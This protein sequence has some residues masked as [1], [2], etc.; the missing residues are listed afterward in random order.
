MFKDLKSKYQFC[1]IGQFSSKIFNSWKKKITK[2]L[3]MIWFIVQ[4]NLDEE[5]ICSIKMLYLNWEHSWDE[6][7]EKKK[8]KATY[9]YTK[10]NWFCIIFHLRKC[11]QLYFLY[12]LILISLDALVCFCFF[13]KILGSNTMQLN[14]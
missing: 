9:L 6:K 13:I 2:K 1:T 8:K 10:Q 11:I 12:I 14:L 3:I 5:N 7:Q 4:N